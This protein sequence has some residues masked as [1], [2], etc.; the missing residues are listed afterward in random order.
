MPYKNIPYV[1][2]VVP[3]FN[4]EKY[5][6]KCINSIISQTLKNIEI[7]IIDDGSTDNSLKIAQ[8]LEKIDNRIKVYHKS[9]G[10][11][12]SARNYGI[13]K[14]KGMYVGFVD[15]DD[16]VESGMFK[17][18]FDSCTKRN[19]SISICGWYIVFE[20][21]KT[22]CSFNTREIDLTPV[23]AI[24]ML[25]NHFS[26]DNFACNKLFK[27][28][29]FDNVTFPKGKV[30]EDLLTI[31]KL[32]ANSKKITVSSIPL[33]YYVQH[34]NSITYN[35]YYN[36]DVKIF[37]S[38]TIR[39][40]DLL[41]LYPQLSSKIKSNYF[42]SNKLYFIISLKSKNR[43]KSFEKERIKYMRKNIIYVLKDNSIP[44]R[45]KISSTLIYILRWENERR[46]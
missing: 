22:Q 42:T 16:Y 30:L 29:L 45:V 13:Q 39:Y 41:K 27:K 28:E 44:F 26:F 12:S 36:L 46:I 19:S 31:Y 6:E 43:D 38:F 21:K 3:V 5:L 34:E 24:N 1:S 2:I 8:S 20:N 32:I 9:N 10:G 4:T 11:L 33:Y 40:K 15:S 37:D 7:I 18:L 35:Q 14:A 23:E 25:L 17:Y